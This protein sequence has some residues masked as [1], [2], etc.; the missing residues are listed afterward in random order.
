MRAASKI[1]STNEPIPPGT[2]RNP[3]PFGSC[4]RPITLHNYDVEPQIVRMFGAGRFKVWNP[5]RFQT[6]FMNFVT[7]KLGGFF[8]FRRHAFRHQVKPP[9]AQI[10]EAFQS[11]LHAIHIPV[12]H[13]FL[14]G[15]ER[16]IFI[17]SVAVH[18]AEI[19]YFRIHPRNRKHHRNGIFPQIRQKPILLQRLA[20]LRQRLDLPI[21]QKKRF[22]N[23]FPVVLVRFCGFC[24]LSLNCVTQKQKRIVPTLRGRRV[25]FEFHQQRLKVFR[26]G[27]RIRVN[28]CRMM[29]TGFFRS[30]KIRQNL[31]AVRA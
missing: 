9:E 10:L 11:F 24:M 18:V 30:H 1:R 31:I 13:L 23:Q 29:K 5:K 16:E 14:V 2:F 6:S 22:E 7:I 4:K 27:V 3:S 15:L 21:G 28:Q 19:R 12:Q 17:F 26:V 20:R 25:L 8:I